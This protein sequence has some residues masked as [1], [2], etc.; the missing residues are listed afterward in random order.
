MTF[1]T[2]YFVGRQQFELWDA[3]SEGKSGFCLAAWHGIYL[4]VC[5]SSCGVWDRGPPCPRCQERQATSSHSAIG[6]QDRL[7]CKLSL[8]IG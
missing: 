1:S 5:R 6:R 3:K 2:L 8:A 4:A 7:G